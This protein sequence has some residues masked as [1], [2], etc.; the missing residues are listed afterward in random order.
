M[1]N[2]NLSQNE[3]PCNHHPD[4]ENIAN[5]PKGFHMPVTP[6]TSP[7]SPTKVTSILILSL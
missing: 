5:M 3:H 6:S 7:Y 4:K 1:C 2:S